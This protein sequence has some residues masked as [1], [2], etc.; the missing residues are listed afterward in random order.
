MESLPLELK[1]RVCS[2]LTPKDL[3]SLR[4]TS[5]VFASAACRNFLPRV[6]L[7]NHPSSFEEIQDIANHPDLKH[8]V[9]T[10]VID[11]SCLRSYPRYD[12]WARHFRP[13][14]T[15]RAELEKVELPAGNSDART[16]RRLRREK[17]CEKWKTYQDRASAQRK[18]SSRDC[19][20]NSI[21]LAFQMCPRL[22]N[23]VIEFNGRN[24]NGSE[25]CKRRTRLSQNDLP[26]SATHITT[27]YSPSWDPMT[28]DIWDLLKP[29][30]DVDRALHSLVLLDPRLVCPKSSTLPTTSIFTNLK[31]LRETDCPRDV[32]TFVTTSAPALES[33]GTED[34]FGRQ[35]GSSMLSLM[36]AP[37]LPKLRACSLRNPSNEDHL[38]RF[39]LRQSR[40]LQR[41]RIHNSVGYSPV[42]WNSFVT[43]AKGKLPN[44][45]RV[46]L[47]NLRT[48]NTTGSIVFH[49]MTENDILQ[50]HEHKLETGPLEIEDGLCEDYEQ[51]FFPEKIR[52]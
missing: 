10:L 3:K 21:A 44:L 40:T 37:P 7:H 2:Y 39:L 15:Y 50:D 23:L 46:E 33:F 5:K 42:N 4:L 29:V 34:V 9:T 17:V 48:Y 8:S 43:R 36:N 28:F 51:M 6:F 45:R 11:T 32:L 18:K 14:P 30:H 13:T 16:V 31:H 22:R 20:L 24:Q 41:L 27:S 38:I 26:S 1:Q 19:M 49:L 52:S 12:D 35:R 25:L 47:V